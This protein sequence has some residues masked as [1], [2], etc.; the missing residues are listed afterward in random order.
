[1]RLI[2][3]LPKLIGH[4]GASKRAPENTLAS[5]RLAKEEGA[6]FVEFDVKLTADGLPILMHDDRLSR[7]TNG[8]GR[9]A[10]IESDDLA[11]LDAG[12]WFAPDYAGEPVPSLRTALA[13]AADLG[14]GVNVE[15]KPCRGRAE[16]TAQKALKVIDETWPDT[17]PAPLISSFDRDALVAARAASPAA[18]L[19][20]LCTRVPRS[21]RR[22]VAELGCS[23]LNVSS[24]WIRQRHID[25]ARDAGIPVLV[26]TVNDPARA[27]SLLE[28]GVTSIFTDDVKT[29]AA[30]INPER[31]AA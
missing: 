2:D 11:R 25:A 28:A 31:A 5:L 1:M 15:L 8:K 17:L 29:L 10:K 22:L 4:R 30:V 27:A 21:W 14:I 7:T 16:E 26:Y 20:F 19:G 6:S 3:E 12:S 18:G 13:L 23:T 9:V 24:R